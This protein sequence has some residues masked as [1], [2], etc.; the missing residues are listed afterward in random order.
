MPAVDGLQLLLPGC[1]RQMPIELPLLHGS[2]DLAARQ[3]ASQ[4]GDARTNRGHDHGPVSFPGPATLG[5][6][7]LPVQ[8][9]PCLLVA[10][11]GREALGGA[12]LGRHLQH[13]G[14]KPALA[15]ELRHG[16]GLPCLMAGL[17]VLFAEQQQVGAGPVPQA[18]LPIAL[19]GRR[20]AG[21][22]RRRLN[23]IAR[24]GGAAGKQ[25]GQRQGHGSQDGGSRWKAEKARH[26]VN[27]LNGHGLA[28]QVFAMAL[29]L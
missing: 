21:L 1:G 13:Q 15:G 14:G 6:A 2:L 7:L 9:G 19:R 26:E 27:L 17:V 22:L 16:R 12:A 29:P 20:D 8:G 24:H 18:A 4:H 10:R 11:I 28:L 23:G 5:R 25:G 3:V